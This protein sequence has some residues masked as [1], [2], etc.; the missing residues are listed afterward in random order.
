MNPYFYYFVHDACI[1]GMLI[2][3]VHVNSWPVQ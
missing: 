2:A 1:V 3:Y